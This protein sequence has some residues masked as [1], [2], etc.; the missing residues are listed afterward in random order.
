MSVFVILD[1]CHNNV[2]GQVYMFNGIT[3]KKINRRKK[4]RKQID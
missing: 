3:E 2:F 1:G 4:S